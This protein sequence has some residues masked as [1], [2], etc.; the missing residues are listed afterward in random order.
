[1]FAAHHTQGRR[2]VLLVALGAAA[3]LTLAPQTAYAAPPR[4]LPGGISTSAAAP[5]PAGTATASVSVRL[6]EG[7]YL[8]AAVLL[9]LRR[10][11]TV[12]PAA[13]PVWGD[14]ISWAYVLVHRDGQVIEGFCASQYLSSYDDAPPATDKD[15]PVATMR[16][17][18]TAYGGLRL[19]SGPGLSYGVDRIAPRHA[20]LN[21]TGTTREADGITWMEV[22]VGG[23][24]L[25]G[26]KDYLQQVPD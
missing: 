1:M 3:V 13:G 14:G 21:T 19:R 9:V 4:P 7:P 15:A 26:S 12:Y 24:A 2:F 5:V 17:K 6:R 20:V 16:V 11:E 10:G 18:V 23:T 22:V 25:W 8:N